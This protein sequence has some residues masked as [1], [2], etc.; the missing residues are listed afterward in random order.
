MATTVATT[1]RPPFVAAG[2]TD[3]DGS[4]CATTHPTAGTTRGLS[5][6]VSST[7]WPM[8]ATGTTTT[9]PMAFWFGR[10]ASV[11]TACATTLVTTVASIKISALGATA[12]GGGGPPRAGTT[13][14]PR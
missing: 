6:S 8:V 1:Q 7:T 11:K 13:C 14:A 5:T 2:G 12:T 9:C 3:M 4:L 10:T